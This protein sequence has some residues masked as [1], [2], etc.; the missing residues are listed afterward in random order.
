MEILKLKAP[1]KD[2]LWGG[3]RLRKDFG[4]ESKDEIIAESWE[5]SLHKDG[6]T[7]IDSAPYKNMTLAS[8][9]EKRTN[10]IIGKDYDGDR[11]PILIK[12]IDA[13]KS[14]SIQVH[15]QDDYA[16]KYENDNGKTEMW[17]I[18][19]ADEDSFIYYGLKKEVSKEAF[20]KA[21]ENSDLE[22]ILNKVYVKAGDSFLIEA[23][24]IHAIGAGILIY[25]VQQNSNVTYRV[26]DYNRR[27]KDGN[28]RQLHIDKALEVS[29]LTENKKY[30]FNSE[31]TI[32][33]SLR[34]LAKSQYF[35]VFIGEI[36]NQTYEISDESFHAISVVDGLGFIE[37]NGIK[38]EFKKGQ[39]FFIP[40][41]NGSYTIKGQG[42]F[43]LS[44]L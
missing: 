33:P 6:L 39:S 12:F 11:F 38:H 24:T 23:G 10:S 27:D 19:D 15:P 16:R 29:N 2:Y 9:I 43:I 13:L 22:A 44:R 41:Q 7:M 31:N 28:L 32:N 20:K 26:Y 21:I 34:R 40:A 30:T 3:N 18:V 37:A 35:D 42:K 25:E 4:K 17:Y 8:L 5:L 14:L 1:T 36:N